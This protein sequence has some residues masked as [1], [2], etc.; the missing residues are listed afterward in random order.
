MDAGTRQVAEAGRKMEDIVGAV[1]QM[2]DIVGEIASASSEQSAG[3][4]QVGQAVAM[5]DK[6][7]Q[8]NAA[9]V[10]EA[11][12]ASLEDQV[13][14]MRASVAIFLEGS[15]AAL[16]AAEQITVGHASV[17]REINPAHQ[18]GGNVTALPKRSVRHAA[19]KTGTGIEQGWEEL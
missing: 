4:Q 15:S 3:I 18:L 9:L 17:E 6:I 2:T 10:E 12:A 16:P 8:Q 5:L 14:E 19:R 1:R 7:T 11:A 13:N